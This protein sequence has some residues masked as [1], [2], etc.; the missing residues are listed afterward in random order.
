MPGI[1]LETNLI[2]FFNKLDDTFEAK[3]GLSPKAYLAGN[4]ILMA[5]SN[6]PQSQLIRQ[7]TL[8]RNWEWKGRKIFSTSQLSPNEGLGILV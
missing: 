7:S 5:C 2:D 6:Y 1:K 3:Y 4:N 8:T